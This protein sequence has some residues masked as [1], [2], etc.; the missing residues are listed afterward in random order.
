MHV[1]VTS[2]VPTFISTSA[3]HRHI[4]VRTAT[5]ACVLYVLSCVVSGGGPD[6]LL[7]TDSGKSALVVLSSVL[8]HS[9]VPPTRV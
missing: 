1:Y 9:L 3:F 6:I 2:M 8:F 5:G 4:K 7:I